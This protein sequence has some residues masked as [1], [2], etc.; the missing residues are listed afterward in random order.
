MATLTSVAL[1]R[2]AKIVP[3]LNLR[4]DIRPRPKLESRSDLEGRVSFGVRLALAVRYPIRGL[5]GTR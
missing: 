2:K 1:S 5:A 3:D 4:S